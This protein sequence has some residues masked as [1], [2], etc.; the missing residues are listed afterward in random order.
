MSGQS[1][2]F[3]EL[4]EGFNN[5]DDK[6]RNPPLLFKSTNQNIQTGGEFMLPIP[7]LSGSSVSYQFSTTDGDILFST[8][9]SCVDE[10][11]EV[12]P[13]VR[14]ASD[15]QPIVG[16]FK[17]SREGSL[18]LKWDNSFSW[19]TAKLLTYQIQLYQ[20]AF[21][22]ADSAR[23]LKS[24]ALLSSTVADIRLAESNLTHSKN[25]LS[26]LGDEIP[27]LE[28]KLAAL[29]TLL[30]DK[31]ARLNDAYSKA[32]ETSARIEANLEKKNGLC[33]R[34]VIVTYTMAMYTYEYMWKCVCSLFL[35]R[36]FLQFDVSSC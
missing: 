6:S 36:A 35:F 33:M 2:I 31:K 12:S 18:V 25:E 14:V 17:A 1:D 20:P 13:P 22:T 23:C 8:S 28:E 29:R 19:F 34:Y 32:E 10:S 27:A 21:T 5:F 30:R 7:V 16:K 3:A 9:F 26:A 11:E 24:R 15:V 4:D